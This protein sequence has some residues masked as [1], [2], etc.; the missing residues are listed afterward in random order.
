M[1][2][3]YIIIIIIIIINRRLFY[4]NSIWWILNTI[5]VWVV[6]RGD[7]DAT[8]SRRDLL[9]PGIEPR[10]YAHFPPL[11]PFHVQATVQKK[12][13]VYSVCWTANQ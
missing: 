8:E 9:L 2:C 4:L 5:G 12:I 7:L 10:P 11:L 1:R 6:S 13:P 3:T